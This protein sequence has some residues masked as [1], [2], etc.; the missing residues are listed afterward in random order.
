M[1]T[2]IKDV[3][4]LILNELDDRS[5]LTI[6]QT[7]KYFKNLCKD[8]EFW[9][10]RYYSKFG[11]HLENAVN[12]S[13]EEY[14][15]WKHK[16]LETIVDLDEFSKDPFSFFDLLS[17]NMLKLRNSLYHNQ[18][19]LKPLFLAPRKILN[20]F[21]FLNLGDE[22]TIYLNNRDE[23]ENKKVLVQKYIT[24]YILY[25]FIK[26]NLSSDFIGEDI[27]LLGLTKWKAG[28]QAIFI[29]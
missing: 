29:F 17:L 18:I 10:R 20:N 26:K 9:R 24:P 16:Y 7:N 11:Q 15:T 3:D 19:I 5:L 21:Y 8:D 23:P 25:G 22:V 27:S 14:Q 1:S 28:Y 6:C 4:R 12:L 13:I 2:G